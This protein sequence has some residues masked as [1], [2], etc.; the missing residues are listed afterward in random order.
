MG[1]GEQRWLSHRRETKGRGKQ[2]QNLDW[3]MEVQ[4]EATADGREEESDGGGGI[5]HRRV[6]EVEAT[7]IRRQGGGGKLDVASCE[8]GLAGQE[9]DPAVCRYA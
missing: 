2:Q 5:R 1:R 3:R 9:V 8:V 4:W 6:G 7:W